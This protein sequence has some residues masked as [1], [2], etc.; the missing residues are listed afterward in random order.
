MSAYNPPIRNLTIFDTLLFSDAQSNA[1]GDLDLR[2]L[3]FPNAQ[4]TEN[5]QGVNVSGIATFNNDLRLNQTK[6]HLGT[7]SGLVSQGTDA[8]AIGG[9]SAQTSQGADAIAI[10]INCASTSQGAQAIAIGRAAGSSNQGAG[11][12]A[13]GWNAATTAQAANSIQINSTGT[14]ISQGTASSCIIAPIRSVAPVSANNQLFYNTTTNEVFRSAPVAS[15]VIGG[16]LPASNIVL[17]N[18]WYTPANLVLPAAGVYIISWAFAYY[19]GGNVVTGALTNDANPPPSPPQTSVALQ[20]NLLAFCG[21]T[22]TNTNWNTNTLSYIYT[23]T[24]AITLTF[25]WATAAAGGT[26]RTTAGGGSF[27]QA[28]RI[29]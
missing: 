28:V 26:L 17:G 21:T 23:A 2:Y 24:G 15:S 27:L 11:S 22:T 12:I 1:F 6:I 9:S 25:W 8:I 19:G 4:G 7:N 29:A 5:L 3:K 10:G 13:I 14:T 16:V 20:A 18:T